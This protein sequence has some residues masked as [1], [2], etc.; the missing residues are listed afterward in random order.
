MGGRRGSVSKKIFL[1]DQKESFFGSKKSFFGSKKIFPR[2]QKKETKAEGEPE[3]HQA[4]SKKIF[5]NM[6][7]VCAGRK[8]RKKDTKTRLGQSERKKERKQHLPAREREMQRAPVNK[9]ERTSTTQTQ[10]QPDIG[11]RRGG[12]KHDTDLRSGC[13]GGGCR[14]NMTRKLRSGCGGAGG[15]QTEM[16]RKLRSGCCGAGG[17][18]KR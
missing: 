9:K 12:E 14:K 5:P 13:G 16:S 4:R 10:R 6:E 15:Q 7:K 18:K 3:P 17:R 1:L 11:W 8:E 2:L